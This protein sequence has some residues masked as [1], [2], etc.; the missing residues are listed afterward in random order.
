MVIDHQRG[1]LNSRSSAPPLGRVRDPGKDFDEYDNIRV[2][3]D[4]SFGGGD[5]IIEVIEEASSGYT[6]ASE[7]SDRRTRQTRRAGSIVR[8]RSRSLPLR[9]RA[10][11]RIVVEERIDHGSYQLPNATGE[12]KL[13]TTQESTKDPKGD[14]TDHQLLLM[15]PLTHAFALKTKQWG[16]SQSAYIQ[17]W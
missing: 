16:R 6:T 17:L 2:N 11:E 14:L 4:A 7:G 13:E 8:R 1:L 10:R 3:D 12:N 15:W 5:D 9:R